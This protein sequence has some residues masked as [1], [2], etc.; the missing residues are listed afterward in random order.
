MMVAASIWFA[1]ASSPCAQDAAKG[2]TRRVEFTGIVT[3]VREREISPRFDGAIEKIHFAPGQ[4]VEKGALLFEMDDI[5]QKNELVRDRARLRHAQARLRQTERDLKVNQ[6]LRK[7]NVASEK[8]LFD[9]QI[10]KDLAEADVAA[11][12][13][14]AYA[15]ELTVKEMKLYA[16]F[17]GIMGRPL[18]REGTSINR[19]GRQSV[20]LVTIT[21]LDPIQVIGHVSYDV[22]ASRRELLK[23]DA[24]ADRRLDISLVLPNGDAFPHTGRIVAGGYAF[25]R[26][27]QEIEVVVEFPNPNYLLRPGLAVTLQANVELDQ[28]ASPKR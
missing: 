28:R 19:T 25:N 1:L 10:A 22:Y 26:D 11:A 24:K 9:A 20:N 5:V 14:Q 18:V 17:A 7:R 3:A 13:I 21:Q 15:A 12:D 8:Q 4:F 27:M 2:A 23:T 6:D 16:P